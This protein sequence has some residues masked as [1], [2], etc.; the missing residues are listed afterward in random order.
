MRVTIIVV[1][2]F[3]LLGVVQT[4][5]ALPVAQSTKSALHPPLRPG[6]RRAAATQVELTIYWNALPWESDQQIA[7][8][9][10]VKSCSGQTIAH[11]SPSYMETLQMEGGGLLPGGKKWV[12]L[13]GR[14]S[15]ASAYGCYMAS[16]G[17][18]SDKGT[19]LVPFVDVASNDQYQSSILKLSALEG[20]LMPD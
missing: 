9:T 17:P 16:S 3:A 6:C 2:L 8:C 7:G 14:S 11:V 15:S 4:I 1:K 10:A 20:V 18:L 12:T 5:T 13:V 19:M